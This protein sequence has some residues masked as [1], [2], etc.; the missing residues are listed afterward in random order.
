MRCIN[1]IIIGASSVDMTN[2]ACNFLGR[3]YHVPSRN[4]RSA[5]SLHT[6]LQSL[7]CNCAHIC[8]VHGIVIGS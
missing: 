5:T 3:A 2:I 7:G 4:Y 1:V 8:A 6:Q